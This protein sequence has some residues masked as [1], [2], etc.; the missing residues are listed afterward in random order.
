VEPPDNVIVACSCGWRK[1]FDTMAEAMAEREK[2]QGL[3]GEHETTTTGT[4]TSPHC[5]PGVEPEI[6]PRNTFPDCQM[7]WQLAPGPPSWLDEVRRGDQEAQEDVTGLLSLEGVARKFAAAE[8]DFAVSCTCGWTKTFHSDMEAAD[9]R[10]E[11][12]WPSDP[13]HKMTTSSAVRL[14]EDSPAAAPPEK[15]ED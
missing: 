3:D 13:A 5:L 1:R 6:P 7:P 8:H 12:Q 4:P 10:C 11:H 15:K 9:G 14:E 2:H